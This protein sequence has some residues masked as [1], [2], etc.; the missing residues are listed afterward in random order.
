[1]TLSPR[2]ITDIFVSHYSYCKPITYTWLILNI[3]SIE[4]STSN[5]TSSSSSCLQILGQLQG[6]S[7]LS[8]HLAL[9]DR[10]VCSRI[11]T[12]QSLLRSL[13]S[14]A[15]CPK[16]L[17]K[18]TNMVIWRCILLSM[19]TEESSSQCFPRHIQWKAQRGG[20]VPEHIA[21]ETTQHTEHRG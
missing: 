7:A 11:G 20:H 19:L 14:N 2:E 3:S 6:N 4:D 16:Q 5:R 15:L 18:I 12:Q 9:K 10:A 17:T 8:S 1:M 21:S 13:L